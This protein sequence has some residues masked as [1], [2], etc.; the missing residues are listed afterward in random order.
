MSKKILDDIKEEYPEVTE[1][2]VRDTIT[3][4]GKTVN[5]SQD[6]INAQIA[7]MK[8]IGR[9][10]S[11][12]EDASSGKRP[13]RSGLQR[14]KLSDSERR[15][16]RELK[17]LLRDIPMDESDLQKTWKTAL[18]AIKT[19]LNNQITDLENQIANREKRKPEK[20]PI[21][22]DQEAKD[23]RAKV[24]SLKEALDEIV[25]KP[26]LTEEQK[27]Q[28]AVNG[29]EKSIESLTEQISNKQLEFKKKPSP[30]VSEE[31]TRLREQ[32]KALRNEILQMRKDA[33]IVEK[34]RLEL[35]K[36][37]TQ[38]QITDLQRRIAEKDYAKKEISKIIP[39]DE[40]TKLKAEKLKWQEVYDKDKY[41]QE[42][43]NRTANQKLID[44]LF[45]IWNL[46][47][48]VMATGEMSWILIQGGVQSMSILTRDPSQ[49][50]GNLRRMIVAMGS[51]DK[52]NEW[53]RKVKATEIYQIAKDSKLALTEVD[54]QLDVREE[55][56][57]GD[58]ASAIWDLNGYLAEQIAGK[59]ERTLIGDQIKK[60]FG[61]KKEYAKTVSAREQIK[62]VNPLRVLERGN[63][64]YMNQ[65][66]L[67]RFI[68]G[69]EKLKLEGKD[70]VKDIDD[71]KA[72]AKAI[73]TL[74]G[75]ANV[76]QFLKTT[77]PKVLAA[78]FFSFRNWVS[79][80]N[81]LNPVFYYSLGNYS[82]PSEIFTKK[83]TVAQ[84][85]AISDMMR[86]ITITT[87]MMYLIQA[88]A[89]KDDEGED[90]I[91]IEK[92]PRSSD[93]MKMRM[94]DLRLDPWGGLQSTIT[95]FMRMAMDQTKSTK[96]GEILTGGERFGARTRGELFQDYVSG[97]FNP[98]AGLIW[99]YMH[100]K[101]KTDENGEIYREN[102]F[103]EKFSIAEDVYNIKPMYWEAMNEVIKEQPNLY[104]GL[105]IAAGALGINTQVY[106]KPKEGE[107]S[108]PPKLPS[109]PSMPKLP[110]MP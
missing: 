80:L 52:A 89:G 102:K 103:G 12:L 64:S 108:G 44:A 19:R 21:E 10:I 86:Y 17:E 3:R 88:A 79:K 66:R 82:K 30:I 78:I 32:Q 101:Q 11:G 93:F 55:Q 87:S 65:L 95:F 23:L 98:S 51:A 31:I 14:R 54:H 104:G 83:P 94:G 34:R 33:G 26:E 56:F 27:I 61:S 50:F 2:Q 68:E 92:D 59:Q 38:N 9:L 100:T 63:T 90:V 57:L 39:D 53:E 91:T 43:K 58:Y 1:R 71:Y 105:I 20:T 16:Q 48:V 72:L 62:N 46:P 69:V 37:R 70:P 36:L 75:R 81:M 8:S 40:L 85:I 18:D 22:Y 15:M 6:E 42:L 96:T 28:K 67:N 77:D 5:P 74:T 99:E 97:K 45:G 73:N 35:A 106:G 41:K 84:K 13:L 24:E 25:G 76:P 110:K 47:R 49:F 60:L 4:Y 29:L 109:M 7:K 107:T